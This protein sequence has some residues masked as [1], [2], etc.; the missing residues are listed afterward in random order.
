MTMAS[1]LAP[2]MTVQAQRLA[3]P[4]A[5]AWQQNA[6]VVVNSGPLSWVVGELSAQNIRRTC[7]YTNLHLSNLNHTAAGRC[8]RRPEL[9]LR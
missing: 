2:G 5:F 7:T 1:R 4:S 8:Y 6:V 3:S 9:Y